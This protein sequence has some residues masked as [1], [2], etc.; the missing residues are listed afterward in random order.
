M[1]DFKSPTVEDYQQLKY[2]YKNYGSI[3]CDCN[4]AN[5]IVWGKK[6]NIKICFKD[7][8]LIRAIFD[9]NN[10]PFGYCYP[11]GNGDEKAILELIFEDA[12][13]RNA[14]CNFAMLTND[15]CEKLVSLTGVEYS[16]KELTGDEDYIYNFN[17]LACLPGKK[18]QKKRN[19]IS[20][21]NRNY[22][23]W[24]FEIINDKN[25]KDAMVVVDKWCQNNKIDISTYDEYYAI[26]KTF[27]NYDL[28]K[29][30]GG[31][32]YV[33]KTPVAMTM[34]AAV[35]RDVFDV[36]FEKALVEYD[37]SY[38]KI[39]NEFSKTLVGFK[40]INREEDLG[41]ESL[42]KAKLSYYPEIIL[43]RFMGVIND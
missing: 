3:G 9:K 18:Y 20:K 7:N 40:Y 4:P 25:K 34:G 33:D 31:I 16:F 38:A 21:F 41:I 28:F 15:Q 8:F 1:L 35:N 17:D 27:E 6:Y 22:H 2:Y 23:N 37:G 24:S 29:I 42:R 14:Q 39:N 26:K 5:T 11:M 32:L 30:H 12:N 36:S 43:K 10:K 19:H 13:D